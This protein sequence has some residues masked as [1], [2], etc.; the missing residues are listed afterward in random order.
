MAEH[1]P[2]PHRVPLVRSVNIAMVNEMAM[3]RSNEH[4]HLGSRRCGLDEALRIVRFELGPGMAICLPVDPFYLS[5]RAREFD[6]ATEFIELA[7]R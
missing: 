6:L 3:H 4:R 5:W 1:L 2:G 7:G